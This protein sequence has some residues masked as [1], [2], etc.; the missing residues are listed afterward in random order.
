MTTIAYVTITNPIDPK[1]NPYG[2][3]IEKDMRRDHFWFTDAFDRDNA[4]HMLRHVGIAIRES[5]IGIQ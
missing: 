2:I 4:L 3:T 1:N 5:R